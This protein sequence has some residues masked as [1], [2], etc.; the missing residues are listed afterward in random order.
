MDKIVKK[1]LNEKL[2]LQFIVALIGVLVLV[3]GMFLPYI[4]AVGDMGEYIEKHPDRIEIKDLELTASDLKDIPVI[5][6][7]QIITG[8]YGEDDGALANV[9]VFTF[10]GFVALTALFVIIKKPIA[11][12]IFDLLAYGVF[13]FLS[14]YMKEDFID[15]DKYAWGIGY[16]VI[17]IAIA[18]VFV[19]AIWM[20]VKKIIAKRELKALPVA[21]PVVP[22]TE[23]SAEQPW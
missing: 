4:T 21:E 18:L 10:C 17:Q 13:A 16:T 6:V 11:V 12:M 7:S 15:P 20:L 3:V 2:K 5:S 1:T 19:A 9:I 23:M 14:A 22:A 8:I